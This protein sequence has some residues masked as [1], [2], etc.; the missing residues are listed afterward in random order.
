MQDLAIF[1]IHA[2]A[3]VPGT[4]VLTLVPP[5]D[6]DLSGCTIRAA[7]RG[8]GVCGR[9][10][11]C[12]AISADNCITINF[13]G[14]PPGWAFYDVFL[15]FPSGAEF[16]LLKGELDIADR[17]TPAAPGDLAVWDV[18]A[19]IPAAETGRV[20]II[21][22]RG[23][24]GPKGE[25]GE[26]GPQGPKGDPGD[27]GPAGPQGP[28]GETGE[29]GPVGPQGPKGEPGDPGPAGP[30][31]LKGEPGDPGPAGPQGPKGEPGDPGPAGPQ[32]LK[33]EPGDPGLAGPQ[34]PK[35]DAGEVG[36]AGPQGP[37]GDAG[38]V[39]PVGP[40][41]PKGDAGE[42]GPV[43]P[44]GP[45][46]ETGEAGP[47]GPQ[48]PKGET[49]ETGPAGPRGFGATPG[50]FAWFCGPEENKPEGWLI[51]MGEWLSA[52]QYPELFAAI[53]YIY[54]GSGDSF[55]IPDL[56]AGRRF[57]RSCGHNVPVGTLQEDAMRNL[58]GSFT[59][60][61][62]TSSGSQQKG[63]FKLTASTSGLKYAVGGNQ[64]AVGVSVD[65][66]QE[67]PVADEFRPANIAL[68]PIIKY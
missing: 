35:G 34:G 24:Q 66:S 44:Q 63:I 54:G 3:H 67:V 10:L 61:L 53:G 14:L 55:M 30:Q 59:G 60:G 13:P 5:P 39:G 62:V 41:G 21:I 9:I 49:G 15:A 1:N 22:G 45:K 4:L 8:G 26:T 46:G 64:Y 38:E 28:K 65:V 20:E 23:P 17:I 36:P 16:P 50:C 42:A 40:Q 32:G 43:G 7:C 11:K 18:T 12:S 48:G 37:K 19:T 47:V 27:P 25:T 31:G 52:A 2:T 51:C 6:V 29:A 57:L 33:G 56:Y 58:T 68:L